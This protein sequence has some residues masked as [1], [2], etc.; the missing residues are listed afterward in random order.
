M[1]VLNQEISSNWAVYNGDCVEVLKGLPEN[2][3]GYSI[4]SPP[5]AQL[6]TYSNSLH[7]MGNS[8][9]YDEFSKHFKFFADN[10]FRVMQEGRNVSIHCMNLQKTIQRDGNRGLIDFRG[11]IIR[12]FESAGFSYHAEVT[13]WKDPLIQAVRTKTQGLLHNQLCKDSALSQQGLPDYVVT[14][15][16]PGINQNPIVHPEGFLNCEYPGEDKEGFDD[17]SNYSHVFWRKLASP[18]WFDIRQTNTLNFRHAKG[19]NDEKHVCLASGSLVLTREHGYIEIENVE[20]GY[21]VLTHLGRWKPVLAKKCNGVS[22]TIRVFAQGVADLT[23]TPNHKLWTKN[24]N[25][26]RAKE[27]AT[28]NDPEW[29]ESQNTLG[30]YLNLKLAPEEPNELT[31]N[32]WWIIG[33]WLGDGHRG[34][35]RT[36]GTRGAGLG[37]FII[38]CNHNEAKDLVDR[39]GEH[40]G[41]SVLRRTTNQ[42][43]IKGLRKEVR[44][45]LNRCGSGAKN[46]RLPAEA[47]AL[48]KDKS[49][50]LLEGYLS[51]DGHYVKKHDRHCA[52]SI[53]R[54][55]LLGMSMIAQRA[56]DVVPSVY[57]GRSDRQ[58]E[59]EGRT[60][61]MRQ[62]WI[63]A[64][65]MS[66]GYKKSGWIDH[67]GAWKKVRK[68]KS[69]GEREVWDL[70]IA[71]DES[72]TSE[73]CIVHN[74]P[75]QLDTIERC[76]LL[77]SNENDI[78][79]SPFSGIGS[80]IYQA[81]KMGRKAI[82]IELKESYYKECVK[83]MKELEYE[84][85]NTIDDF[86]V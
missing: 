49:A 35:R 5:F 81:I 61:N 79:L 71:D 58:G 76:L 64:F 30:S 19:Q 80:E 24:V 16:K 42:I 56:H 7:D 46:K 45:T 59:I 65:R 6:F 13:I 77:W 55:L 11:D 67:D 21:H 36:S 3:I 69:A 47:F 66:E 84:E 34:T 28:K 17:D 10:I 20:P 53:S 38:S 48:S 43:A 82:G 54:A 8:K 60:V 22:E 74:C 39:L 29:T 32:E 78:V 15:K 25:G 70:Q 63:F 18:V 37:E 68:I 40:A 86:F 2:S 26:A 33:R 1:K 73:G 4:F 23:V 9:N 31:E 50:A 75:L 85:K 83:I 44:E 57:A 62:D 12:L 52:S 41:Y 51:A 14:F 27:S 72:F